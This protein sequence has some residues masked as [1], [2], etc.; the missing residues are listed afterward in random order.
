MS[1]FPPPPRRTM[2]RKSNVESLSAAKIVPARAEDRIR[3][4]AIAPGIVRVISVTGSSS[5]AGKTWV[6][7]SIVRA[8]HAAGQRTT[9]LK[10]TRTHVDHCPRHNTSCGTCDSLREAFELVT[11]RAALDVP[12][13]DTGRYFQAGADQVLWLIV[14][15]ERVA[16]GVR[17]ALAQVLPGHCLVVEGNSFRDYADADWTV[18][19]LT[20][21]YAVKPSAGP[22]AGRVD[23]FVARASEVQSVQGLSIVGQAGREII[24][25]ADFEDRVSRWWRETAPGSTRR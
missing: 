1:E 6:A 25:D 2:P 11:D 17:A 10:V 7:E 24:A 15:P 21:A 14:R 23:C 12:K 9:A 22:I 5:N 19:A 16:D 4:A 8:L 20:D 18:M 3:T 13:K